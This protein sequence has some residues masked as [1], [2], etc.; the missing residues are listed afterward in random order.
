MTCPH[1][2]LK[3]NRQGQICGAKS[4]SEEIN[5]CRVHVQNQSA[6]RELIDK[7]IIEKPEVVVDLSKP[8]PID[9]QY[10]PKYK[11]KKKSRN[12]KKINN[13]ESS[14]ITSFSDNLDKKLNDGD[15]FTNLNLDDLY[16][17]DFLKDDPGSIDEFEEDS[18]NSRSELIEENKQLREE[19][20]RASRKISSMF[21]L[22]SLAFLGLAQSSTIIESLYPDGLKGYTQNVITNEEINKLLDEMSADLDYLIGLSDQ[23]PYV[24][25]LVAMGLIA[26]TT[27]CENKTGVKMKIPTDAE[28]TNNKMGDSS[29]DEY[30][31]ENDKKNFYPE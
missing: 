31:D 8:K 10:K 7:G 4:V 12:K 6:K 24:R 22:K 2:F 11:Q 27:L 21:S 17:D 15:E 18:E 9:S 26:G 23:P 5:F 14:F 20:L 25:L 30:E 28:I 13:K 29:S 1:V 19:N 16:D 3:G